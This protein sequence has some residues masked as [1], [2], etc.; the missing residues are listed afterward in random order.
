MDNLRA[1]RKAVRRRRREVF[2]LASAIAIQAAS[3]GH[4]INADS[5]V[6]SAQRIV[7]EVYKRYV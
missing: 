4:Y 3:H 6:D 2:Q 7:D 1:R 5:I